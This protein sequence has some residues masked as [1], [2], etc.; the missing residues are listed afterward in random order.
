[1]R[2]TPGLGK[3][4]CNVKISNLPKSI[5]LSVSLLKVEHI[6][7]VPFIVFM[8][9]TRLLIDC[10]STVIFYRTLNIAKNSPEL[11]HAHIIGFPSS[12]NT[13][14]LSLLLFHATELLVRIRPD[15]WNRPGSIEF[16]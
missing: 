10:Q 7:C 5:N 12:F 2:G 16:V 11:I 9:E 3:T 14:S 13:F 6:N 8:C 1:M 4:S 15:N